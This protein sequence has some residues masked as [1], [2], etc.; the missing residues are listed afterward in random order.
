MSSRGTVQANKSVELQR[1]MQKLP[2]VLRKS[3]ADRT[4]VKYEGA[5]AAWSRWARTQRVCSSPADPLHVALYLVWL[6]E[7]AN[8]P[9]PVSAALYG[10][11]WH[12]QLHSLEDPCQSSVVDRVHQAARRI[13]GLGNRL[14]RKWSRSHRSTTLRVP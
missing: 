7:S 8:T 9:A 5:F 2:S 4:V 11:S 14:V 12:H 6:I 13:P 10:I 1:L 3:R